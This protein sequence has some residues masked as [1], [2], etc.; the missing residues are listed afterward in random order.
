MSADLRIPPN[1]RGVIRVF[2]LS[3]TDQDARALK[4]DSDAIDAALGTSVDAN[5]VEVFPVSDLEGVGLVGYLAEGNAVA[6]EQLSPDKAKLDKLGGWVM[7]VFSLAFED[8]ET[9]LEPVAALTLIGTYGEV[10]TD[11]RA[12]ETVE[13]DSAK[14]YSAPPETVKKKPSDAAM[15]GRIAMIALLVLGL[16]TWVMIRIGG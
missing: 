5:Q 11:W 6:A 15:S 9:V 14:P 4:D 10:R 2:A 13:A 8:R 1:E 7:I 12:T 16:L 3:M